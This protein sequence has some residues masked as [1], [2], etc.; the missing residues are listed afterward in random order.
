MLF[1]LPH[2]QC[3]NQQ[4]HGARRKHSYFEGW[5]LK[6]QT[7]STSI[8]LIPAFHRDKDG[9][10]SASIQVISPDYQGCAWFSADQFQVNSETFDVQISENHFSESGID[11][12][13][14]IDSFS[15][16]GH[17][18]YGAFTRLNDH[19]MGPFQYLNF[20]QCNHGIL[21]LFHSLEGLLE[22]NG[23]AVDFSNGSGYI[24]KDWGNSFPQSYL[25][26]QGSWT[27]PS[28]SPVCIFLSIAHIPMPG[29][30]FTGCNGI[31]L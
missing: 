28:G 4:F 8:S 5:Y 10:P 2:K 22:I 21:S 1:H 18:S 11:L 27:F 9:T 16:R 6:H 30:S 3:A 20:L 14:T 19:I 31:I 13:L 12:N 26:T 24:E 25:W 15:V 29:F 7:D 23:T 17:L